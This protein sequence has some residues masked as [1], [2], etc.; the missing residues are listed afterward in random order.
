[1]T[2]DSV[3]LSVNATRQVLHLIDFSCHNLQHIK[4]FKL[5]IFSS[6]KSYQFEAESGSKAV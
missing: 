3:K 6:N 4:P 1:M 5:S 2:L